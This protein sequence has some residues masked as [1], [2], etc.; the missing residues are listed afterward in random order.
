MQ[1]Q[2]RFEITHHA[3]NNHGEELPMAPCTFIAT[4][5]CIK[6]LKADLHNRKWKV[7]DGSVWYPCFDHEIVEIK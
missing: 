2:K 4:E 6:P 3:R 7:F 5:D 1:N